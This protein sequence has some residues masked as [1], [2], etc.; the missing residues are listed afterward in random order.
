MRRPMPLLR[1]ALHRLRSQPAFSALVIGL[2]ALGLGACTALFSVIHAVLLKPLP[3]PAPGELVLV[4][5]LPREAGATIPG[6]GDQVPDTEFSGWRE[7][8]PKSFRQLAAYRNAQATLQRGDGAVRAPAA[9][10][11]DGFFSLL[12]VSA[13]RGR[14]FEP[15]DLKPGATPVTVI[16]HQAWLARFAGADDVLGQVIRLDDTAHTVIGIL[17]PGFEFTDP[18]QFWRPLIITPSAPGQLRIQMVRVFGRLRTG[19]GLDTAQRELEG[20]SDR[21]WGNLSGNLLAGPPPAPAVSPAPAAPTASPGP[22]PAERRIVATPAP[23]E[24][25]PAGGTTLRPAAPPGGARQVRLPFADA[26]VKLVIL[27][28]HLT[29]QARGTLWLLL[30]AVSLVLLIACANLANLQLARAAAR[31]RDSAIRAALG[32]SPWRLGAE[33]LAENLGLALAGGAL[34]LLLAWW[35]TQALEAWLAGVLPRLN[36]IGLNLPVAGFAATLAVG[37]G[38]AFGLAPAWQAARADLLEPLKDGGAQTSAA[39]HRGR[40]VLVALELALA[41]V[42][43]VNTALLARSLQ[44]LYANELGHRTEDVLTANLALP[45]RYRT[46]AQQRDFAARWLEVLRTLPGVK[47]AALT[48][49][50]PLSPYQ[51]MVLSISADS[52]GGRQNASVSSAPPTMAVGAATPDFFAATGIALR[53]GR[54]FTD[55]DGPEAP[56]VAV[57]NE[58][59]IK[60]FHPSG[61]TPGATVALPFQAAGPRTGPPPSARIVGVVADTRPRGFESQ[62]QP[63]A[64]FP[65][66]QQP[67]ARLAAV[68]HFD[69]DAAALARAVTAATHKVDADLALD[70]PATLEDQLA[71]QTAPRRITLMLTATFAGAAVLLA[72]IGLF[73]VMSYTVTLRTGE[74]GVRMALG[75]G[76]GTI[77]RWILRH[78]LIAMAT[79]LGIGVALTFATS[80]LLQAHL[81]GV[82]AIDPLVFSG[83]AALLALAGLAACSWP[84]WRATR[85][86]PVEALRSE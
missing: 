66:A 39:G 64:W 9:A 21:F 6:G 3:Y 41:L 12:G 60:T 57:V 54:L 8:E 69:G 56:A 47:T 59:F 27:Q 68:L 85:I 70:Q 51:Q 62:P 44:K 1:S 74:I 43:A 81:P 4:R 48:D 52:R 82:T 55:T 35:G 15:A 5:K 65:L 17:P 24:A 26:A 76:P 30:G 73:G 13:W 25:A 50:P 40:Q 16:S 7:A 28:E 78:G 19:T 77:L 20:I 18:V 53:Q 33:L 71:R 72:V 61:F 2:L 11:T 34:G 31:R 80:K 42:L 10:I 36:P 37:T 38:L 58:T 49:V 14:L 29:R 23:A 75:A 79:G 83:V 46:P 67:R 32:A 63:M 84:A 86:N 45:A 22:V